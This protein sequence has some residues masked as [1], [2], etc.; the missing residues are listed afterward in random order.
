MGHYHHCTKWQGKEKGNIFALCVCVSSSRKREIA[1]RQF[2]CHGNRA[3]K[4]QVVN[5]AGSK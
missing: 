5:E 3:W 4:C 2:L 1:S